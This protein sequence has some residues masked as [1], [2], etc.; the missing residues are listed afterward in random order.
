LAKF[1]AKVTAALKS[2]TSYRKVIR[3]HAER[4]LHDL[5]S[6]INMLL[7]G[8]HAALG[9][10]RQQLCVVFDNLEKFY[11]RDLIDQAVLRR[12][13]EFRLL[14]CHLLLFFSPADQY[15]PRTIQA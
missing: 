1:A 4:D 5:V 13:D 8:V 14:H 2:N 11:R 9:P 7:D 6:R 12:A 3:S 10:R 15:A